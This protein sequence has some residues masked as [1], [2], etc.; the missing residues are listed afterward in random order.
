MPVDFNV[1]R[2]LRHP[3][4]QILLMLLLIIP[5]LPTRDQSLD[6]AE[7]GSVIPTC[8]VQLVGKTR[9]FE[10]LLEERDL[11]VGYRDIIRGGHDGESDERLGNEQMNNFCRSHDEGGKHWGPGV[12]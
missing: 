12:V 5:V 1:P 9:Q 8:H 7:G 11:C 2:E 10:F 6:V 4:V 3:L